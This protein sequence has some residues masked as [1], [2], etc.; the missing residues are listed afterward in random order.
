[1]SD[2][3]RRNIAS[4]DLVRVV[5]MGYIVGFWHL[6]NYVDGYGGYRNEVTERLTVIVLAT[7]TMLSGYLLGRRPVEPSLAGVSAFYRRRLLRVYP[8]LVVALIVFALLSITSWTISIRSVVLVSL[9]AGPS[10][11]TLWYV[12]MIVL[13]YA[14][15]PILLADRPIQLL[16]K[17]IA[18]WFAGGALLWLGLIGL[19]QS[20]WLAMEPRLALYFP[21]FVAGIGLAR[22]EHRVGTLAAVAAGLLAAVASLPSYGLT[23]PE[24][25][26]SLRSAPMAL[27]AAAFV[28]LVA[29]RLQHRIPHHPAVAVLSCA[30]FF[31]YLAHRPVYVLATRLFPISSP[32]GQLAFM[33]LVA[34]PVV[35]VVSWMLQRLYDDVLQRL[36]W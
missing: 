9:F 22:L 14:V 26:L 6:M 32:S 3:R 31:A 23:L 20:G 16:G 21:C 8:P 15:A 17:P 28:L 27:F 33:L 34:L 24:I 7:F 1:M 2:E 30:A 10:A 4:L 13:F 25:E 29:L 18:P 5:A 35:V 19:Q 11:W 36:G 12:C